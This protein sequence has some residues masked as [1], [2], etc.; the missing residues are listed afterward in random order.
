MEASYDRFAE[1]VRQTIPTDREWRWTFETIVECYERALGQNVGPPHYTQTAVELRR[2]VLE[3]YPRLWK[4]TAFD[5]AE[6]K[7]MHATITTAF[8]TD[9]VRNFRE[10]AYRRLANGYVEYQQQFADLIET[11]IKTYQEICTR[12]IRYGVYA[13]WRYDDHGQL[14]S[15]IPTYIGRSSRK[16]GLFDRIKGHW[17]WWDHQLMGVTFTQIRENDDEPTKTCQC[18]ET[19]MIR[20]ICSPGNWKDWFRHE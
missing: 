1:L 5:E 16:A 10:R 15:T 4:T 14:R 9:R 18:T 8:N 19:A 20:V 12:Y 13:L 7:D 11:E 6:L 17:Q 2:T 3:K